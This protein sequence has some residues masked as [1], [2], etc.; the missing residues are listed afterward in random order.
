M[1]IRQSQDC[2][3]STMGIPILIRYYLYIE[4]APKL[5]HWLQGEPS[6]TEA[7]M[8][9]IC[10]LITW[11]YEEFMI[12]PKNIYIYIYIDLYISWIMLCIINQLSKYHTVKYTKFKS[13]QWTDSKQNI[14]LIFIALF[15]SDPFKLSVLV[16]HNNSNYI[17]L[18]N[19]QMLQNP[20]IMGF[21]WLKN[22]QGTDK[23][24]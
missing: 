5:L 10:K 17:T 18:N 22:Q 14:H 13:P 1:E 9:N 11:I 15:L 24:T 4:S 19:P 3:I 6:T 20:F 21:L 2:L 23:I 12:Y 7:Y 16:S 8:K